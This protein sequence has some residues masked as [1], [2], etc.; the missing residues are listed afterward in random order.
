M[1]NIIPISGIS[2][3]WLLP[4]G[5]AELLYGQGPATASAP[6]R[7]VLFVMPMTSAGTWTP[8]TLYPVRDEITARNGGGVGS[9]V[10]RAVRKFLMHNKDAKL[11]VVP[12]AASS[13]AGVA[14]ATSTITLSGTITAGGKVETIIAGE[15]C[16][17]AFSSGD[18]PTTIGDDLAA[19]I[20]A[21]D[22]LPVT[23]ANASGTVT[24]TAKIMGA[25]QGT[26]TVGVIQVHAEY[27]AGTGLSV[28]VS[29]AL[30]TDVAGADGAVTEA[31]NLAAALAAVEMTRKYYI[32][33]SVYDA[34][35]IGSL[36][37]HIVS[38][39]EPKRGLRS[40]GIAATSVALASGI[41]LAT[42]RNHERVSI[43]WNVKGENAPDETV[44]GVLSQVQ[45]KQAV[46]SA[47]NLN[48]LPLNDILLPTYA[49]GDRP[50]EDDLNDALNGGLAPIAS[51]DSGARLV[52]FTTTRSKNAAGTV[53]DRRALVQKR[54]SV[55]DE[56]MDEEL[57]EFALNFSG[58]KLK[59]NSPKEKELNALIDK[60]PPNVITPI[61]FK[62]HIAKRIRDYS[63][64]GKLENADASVEGLRCVLE[65]TS[66]RLG[67]SLDL[68]VIEDLSQVTYRAAEVSTG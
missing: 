20:N 35:S 39:S 7:E 36:K 45:K 67:V 38:K 48:D 23:A 12:Y 46:D 56:F 30:G 34:T 1:A 54:V 53:N 63:D 59:D 68:D 64:A 51:T 61:D 17:T 26:A 44:A 41:T 31:T 3:D 50:T 49:V 11:S 25:S 15:R 52:M 13:G 33:V 29:G 2:A 4:G 32:G 66:G 58:K 37:T 57:V 55:T 62:A 5:Y 18:T 22:W 8:N 47:A 14:A 40:I 19:V 16:E 6:N 28:V 9:S 42:G 60:R 21:R 65:T 24:L 27:S 10:H 43:V